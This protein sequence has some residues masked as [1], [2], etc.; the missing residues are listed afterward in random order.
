MDTILQGVPG[1][2]CYIDDILV[3][4]ATVQEHLQNLE[5]VFRRLQTHGVRMKK[6]KCSFMQDSV[7]YLGHLIDAEGIHAAPGKI[8]AIMEAPKPNNVQ[9]LRSFLGLLSYYRKFL[10]NLAT[11]IQPLNS[12]LQKYKKW[13]WTDTC[14]NA[15]ESAKRLLTNSNLLTHYDPSLPLKLAADASQYGLGAV[16]SHVLQN[17][18]ERPIAFT[19]RALS[20]SEKNYSQIDKEALALIYGVKK[21][22][23]YLFGRK[24]TLVT[25][26]QPLTS[27]FGP[28]KGV[29][30]V[31]AARLQRW[32]L[33]LAA[34]DYDIEFRSTKA[35]GSADALSRL[36]LPVS[37]ALVPSETQLCNIRKIE[38]LPVTSKQ[39]RTATQRDPTLSKVKRYVLRGWPKAVP[40]S[41]KAYY[42]KLAELSIE[43]GIKTELHKEHLGIAKM[44]ALARNHVWWLRI[45]KDL[46][47]LVRSCKDCAAVKQAPAKYPWTWPNRPWERIHI[48]FAGPSLNK[49]FLIIVDAYSKWADVIEMSQTTAARTITVLRNVFASHGLPE[50]IV[51]DNGPQFTSSDFAE[52]TKLN[53]IKHVR[54]SPYHPASNGE[55][56]RFIRTFKEAMKAGRNDGLTVP[57][58]LASFLLTYRTTP[59]ST[60]GIP[61]CEL[62]M[63]RQLRTRWDL[64]KPDMS[65]TV[66]QRQEKQKERHDRH[67]RFRRFEVGQSVMVRNFGSGDSWIPA[68]VAEQLGPVTYL[69]D[70]SGGRIWKRH[71]DHLK[72]FRLPCPPPT[73]ASEP[74]IDVDISLPPTSADTATPE[75]PTER[76]SD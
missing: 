32:S 10:P 58:R 42:S 68:V 22:H 27:I 52:F 34:Y 40:K 56:E 29:P 43:E 57:H 55:A 16:I 65:N 25:D 44:K 49:S 36:P 46:E 38:T 39:I 59:H 19:S 8:T 61:P 26:H 1:A 70:A 3:T 71:V 2:M 20:P 15:M 67:V 24:F 4:G 63:G 62:L 23:D 13:E 48:D 53:G 45:D 5:E 75:P 41:L 17:G 14:S 72:E 50:Q 28:K 73:V 18:D 47:S 7:D 76:S 6:S 9:Q 33:L 54:V 66:R 30:A 74:E 21:F 35:H 37:T 60:T 11:I 31:A 64:L 69:V 12:L 51:S